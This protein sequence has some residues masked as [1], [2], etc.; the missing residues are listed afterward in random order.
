MAVLLMA[1]V[2]AAAQKRNSNATPE[3]AELKGGMIAV[4]SGSN[5][6]AD[7]GTDAGTTAAKYEGDGFETPEKA[8]GAYI[9]GFRNNDIDEMVSAFAIETYV[10]NYSLEKRVEYIGSYYH[11]LG[12]IPT[13]SG[14]SRQ[15][16][17]E[18]RRSQI[19]DTIWT[20][21]LVLGESRLVVGDDAGKDIMLVDP[22]DSAEALID[23][24]FVSDDRFILDKIEF[25]G[26]YYDPASLNEH[27]T[28]DNI[29]EYMKKQMEITGAEDITS[30]VAKFYM[31][32]SPVVLM[33]DAAKYDDRWYLCSPSGIIGS[34]FGIDSYY[35][36]MVPQKYDEDGYLEDLFK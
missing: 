21:Y 2:T 34:I 8:L 30:V 17:V 1:Q 26:E 24:V 3:T 4:S 9:E 6:A 22:Y 5:S 12:Y 31:N 36:G 20:H 29:A 15:L 33:A 13:I 19:L 11:N 16:N 18:K 35:A 25:K 23:D 28:S 32:G 7:S 10:E 14:F 27:Y